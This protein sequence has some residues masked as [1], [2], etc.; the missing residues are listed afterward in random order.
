MGH[1]RLDCDREAQHV[2]RSMLLLLALAAGAQQ[3][4][5]DSREDITI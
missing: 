2:P 5:A 1:V 4:S 3:D